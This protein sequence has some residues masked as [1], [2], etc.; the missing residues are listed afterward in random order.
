MPL[1]PKDPTEIIYVGFDFL[2]LT[3]TP[4]APAVAIELVKGTDATPSAMLSGSPSIVG[5]KVYQKI[6]GGVDGCTYN[7]RCTASAPDGS[8]YV[9]ADQLHVFHF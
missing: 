5:T 6:I 9:L 8:K 7:I 3:D 4:S 2:E 1:S